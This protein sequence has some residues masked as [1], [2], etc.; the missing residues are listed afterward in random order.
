MVSKSSQVAQVFCLV[1][2]LGDY[3]G[4]QALMFRGLGFRGDLP[5]R[6]CQV[7]HGYDLQHPKRDVKS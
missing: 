4:V 2:S 6:A 7:V 1:V 5:D 3:L